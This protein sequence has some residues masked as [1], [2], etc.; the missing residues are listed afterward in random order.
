VSQPLT[1]DDLK[2]G[3]WYRAKKFKSNGITNNDRKIGRTL[4]RVTVEQFLKW[5][6]R[7]VTTAELEAYNQ[8]I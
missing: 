3:Y 8:G 7:R 6:A 1:H 5:A 2:V 4:P